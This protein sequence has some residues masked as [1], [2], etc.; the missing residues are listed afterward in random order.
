MLSQIDPS[1]VAFCDKIAEEGGPVSL[2]DDIG[3][4]ILP[5]TP[6]VQTVSMTRASA[7][8]RHVQPE[9]S[10]EKSHEAIK[11]PNKHN[12]SNN[13]GNIFVWY[14]TQKFGRKITRDAGELMKERCGMI[15]LRKEE[16]IEETSLV[17]LTIKM[18]ESLLSSPSVFPLILVVQ[19]AISL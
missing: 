5:Q 1:L 17:N 2:P 19:T 4:T 6:V 14:E 9:V 8:L 10:L 12:G 16:F 15:E 13:S 11:R 7:R 3:G 18:Q